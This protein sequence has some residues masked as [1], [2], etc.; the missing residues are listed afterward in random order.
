MTPA[1]T[2]PEVALLRAFLRPARHYLEFGCGGSTVLAS[3]IIDGGRIICVDSVQEWLDRVA[4][5]CAGPQSRT[6]P[7]G[8]HVDIGP[9]GKYGRPLD[10]SGVARWPAYHERIWTTLDARTVDFCL[11]DGRFRIAC[12]LQALLRCRPGTPVAVHDYAARPHYHVIGGVAR[13]IARAQELAV[14]VADPA[15]PQAALLEVLARH[16]MDAH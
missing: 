9:T 1:M 16:R 8:H 10:L 14:F 4:E 3:R 11:V 5:A 15:V 7:E 6:R 2:L 13:Q 12:C